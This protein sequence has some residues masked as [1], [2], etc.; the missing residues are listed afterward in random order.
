LIATTVTIG[1]IPVRLWSHDRS[2][3]RLIRRRYG[4]FLGSDN[5]DAA[6]LTLKLLSGA[7]WRAGAD[8]EVFYRSG[9]WHIQRGDFTAEWNMQSRRGMVWQ[10]RSPYALD[11]ILRILHT[12]ILAQRG[13]FL[14]HAA[15]VIG[16]GRALVFAGQ[17]GAGKTTMCRL[18]PPDAVLLSDE[19]SFVQPAAGAYYAFGT[20]FYGELA[21]PGKNTCAPLDAI[22]LLEHADQD[23]VDDVSPRLA[24]PQLLKNVLLF[25]HDGET[26]GRVFAAAFDLISRVP[27]RR[28][29]FAP[30]PRVWSLLEQS[31][32]T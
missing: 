30:T 19:I 21:V 32:C 20:P 16:N 7:G 25:A 23:R 11:S 28:L 26:V 22:Y 17:S 13:G 24:V 12:L 4:S 2:F 10:P 29:R 9:T 8:L 31:A 3:S 5:C 18:A 6:E 15:S 14:L 27:V 1:G